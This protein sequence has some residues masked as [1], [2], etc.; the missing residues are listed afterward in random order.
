MT[1]KIIEQIGI[2]A[3]KYQTKQIDSTDEIILVDYY[4]ENWYNNIKRAIFD[5][6]PIVFNFKIDKDTIL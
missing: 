5:N 4:E 3:S 6:H 2:D 1:L